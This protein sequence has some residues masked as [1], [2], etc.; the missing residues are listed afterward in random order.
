MGKES[1]SIKYDSGAEIRDKEWLCLHRNENLFS[2]QDWF[3]KIAIKTLSGANLSYYPDSTCRV[4]RENLAELYNVNP[5]NVFVGN[6]ADEVLSNLL[7]LLRSSY[8]RMSVLDVCFKVFHLLANRFGFELD[9]IP[10]DTFETGQTTLI[11]WTGLAVIDSPNSITSA[12]LTVDSLK[13]FSSDPKSFLVWD[14]VYGEFA[15]DVLREPLTKNIAIVRSFSKF[16]GLAGMRV[17]YCI[18]DSTIIDALSNRKDVFNVNVLGQLMA[19]EALRSRER[20]EHMSDQMLE[21]RQ[22]LTKRLINLGFHVRKPSGNFLLATH[23]DFSAEF[24][25]RELHKRKIAVRRFPEEPTTNYI[26][27]T[28]P[29]TAC[30]ERLND[31]LNK[32]LKTPR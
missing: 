22:D 12:R 25:Q 9:I 23:P 11:G 6:G 4:L 28:I 16:Y 19:I 8:D 21:C 7:G 27:I 3:V 10:G 18:A 2:N 24:I 17:G 26:R 29:Q 5:E 14:N 31:V 1:K 20:F 30:V 32:I 15:G 13:D